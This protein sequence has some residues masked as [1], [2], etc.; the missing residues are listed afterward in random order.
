MSLQVSNLTG[1]SSVDGI[2]A[3]TMQSMIE[4]INADSNLVLCLDAGDIASWDTGDTSWFD[5][6]AH[7]HDFFVGETTS[8][9]A[10]DPTHN[11]TPGG[12][13]ASEYFSFDGGDYFRL[14]PIPSEFHAFHKANAVFTILMMYYVGGHDSTQFIFGNADNSSDQGVYASVATNGA[15][16]LVVPNG[17]GAAMS[18]GIAAACDVATWQAIAFSVDEA[19]GANGSIKYA[20]NQGATPFDGTYTGPSASDANETEFILGDRPTAGVPLDSGARMGAVC[21]WDRAL[22]QSELEQLCNAIEKRYGV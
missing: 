17:S 9:E 19:A 7:S 6:T 10:S 18:E 20:T 8:A 13:S 21:I 5:T 12:L 14:S 1:F 2:P 15:V 4:Y 22:G 16:T 11:G 3:G